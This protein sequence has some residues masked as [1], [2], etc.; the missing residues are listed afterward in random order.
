M[1]PCIEFVKK[2]FQGEDV[3]GAEIGVYRGDNA[4]NILTNLSNVSLLFL[5]DPYER[6]EG[7][8]DSIRK[9]IEGA[10]KIAEDRLAP[11]S[12]RVK[13]VYKKAEDCLEDI[14]A[15]L[16]FI[17]IDGNHSY[18]FVKKD[19]EVAMK[20]VRSGGVIGGHDY[21]KGGVR[22]AVNEF[23]NRNNIQLHLKLER[24]K[25]SDWWFIKP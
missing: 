15:P 7:W 17:Y 22:R 3:I 1:R 11:F 10:R 21:N 25:H 2:R 13:W 4:F 18:K 24:K 9:M 14:L 16:A 12:E 20:L 5:I 23:C 6:Y 19:I 8:K